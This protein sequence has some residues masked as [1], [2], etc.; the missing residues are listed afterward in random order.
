MEWKST[1][2]NCS[3]KVGWAT[4][5]DSWTHMDPHGYGDG[6]HTHRECIS[7]AVQYVDMVVRVWVCS[8]VL[9][10][11]IIKVKFNNEPFNNYTISILLIPTILQ[12]DFSMFA[13]LILFR[14]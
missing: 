8:W 14:A 5:S 2:R 11:L 10:L 3:L 6:K 7:G 1:Y 12:Y 9:F 13:I 4:H